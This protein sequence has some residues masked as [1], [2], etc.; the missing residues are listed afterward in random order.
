VS[1][2]RIRVL[3]ADD[4]VLFAE[5][6]R[7]IL[8]S[9]TEDI[10]VVGIARDGREA[11]ELTGTHLPDIVLMDV[12]M[13]RLDGVEA[14][15]AIHASHPDIKIMMLTTFDDD[16]YVRFSLAYG[17]IGYLLKNRPPAELIASIRAVMSGVMQIDPAVSKSLIRDV[18]ARDIPKD[19]FMRYLGLLTH[20]E[21]DV[22]K[23]LVE[24]CDNRQ[25]SERMG[26]AEQTVRNYV[27]LIYSKLG[28]ENRIEIMRHMDQIRFFLE[29]FQ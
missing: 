23:L 4:Q 29:H 19:E 9:R 21:K 16:E 3:I 15:K 5:G 6:L 1:T 28:I 26:I 27:S 8:E 13:P 17:A 11:V 25:I 14:T 12:R 24:A 18:R 10:T 20:R 2:D 22:L 7:T